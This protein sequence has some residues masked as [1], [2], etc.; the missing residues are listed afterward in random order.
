M[1]ISHSQTIWTDSR[2]NKT[3]LLALL[4]LFYF[5]SMHDFGMISG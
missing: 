4:I 5:A 1:F 2:S 3:G